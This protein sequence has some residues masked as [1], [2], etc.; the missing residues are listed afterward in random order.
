MKIT[1]PP[2]ALKRRDVVEELPRPARVERG[3]RL[4]EDHEPRPARRC[5]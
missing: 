4:V 1:A 2:A 5:R 3:G